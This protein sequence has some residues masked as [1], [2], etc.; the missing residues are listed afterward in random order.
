MKENIKVSGVS[1]CFIDEY[2]LLGIVPSSG[3]PNKSELA[4]WN[5]LN[6]RPSPVRFETECPL[7]P[8]TRLDRSRESNRGLPFYGDPSKGIVCVG[9]PRDRFLC[10]AVLVILA[11]DLIAL[12]KESQN[13]TVQWSQWRGKVTDLENLST[14]F[15]V[16][17]SQV[18][19]V[20][21]NN[22]LVLYIYDFSRR[23]ERKNGGGPLVLSRLTPKTP[24]KIELRHEGMEHHSQYT[25]GV[26]EG[27]V[28]AILVS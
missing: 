4:L 7:T 6:K 27:G 22:T 11:R 1:I 2:Q 19:D 5:T 18:A 17:H 15:C 26:T 20:R 28:Y 9:I 14:S 25:F 3:D 12:S 24:K 10:A 21:E 23:F 8:D 13:G 16:L